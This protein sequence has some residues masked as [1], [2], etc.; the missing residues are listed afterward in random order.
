MFLV[1]L[2]ISSKTFKYLVIVPSGD[3]VNKSSGIVCEPSFVQLIND[4]HI[5]FSSFEVN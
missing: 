4:L 5:S 3:C 1:C 2:K